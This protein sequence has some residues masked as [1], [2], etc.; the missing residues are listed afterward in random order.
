M[1]QTRLNHFE[2]HP[3]KSEL[4]SFGIRQYDICKTLGISQAYISKML[5]G[6]SPM[7][8]A[9]E[10]KIRKILTGLKSRNRKPILMRH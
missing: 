1:E 8:K 7:P 6:L 2:I 9:I 3:L 10:E 4:V 5:N